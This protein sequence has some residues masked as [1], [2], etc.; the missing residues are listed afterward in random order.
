MSPSTATHVRAPIQRYNGQM[1]SPAVE[2]FAWPNLAQDKRSLMK[3][4]ST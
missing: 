1:L 4:S 2:F 3:I